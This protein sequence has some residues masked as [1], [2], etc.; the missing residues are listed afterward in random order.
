[1]KIATFLLINAIFLVLPLL[2]ES[3]PPANRTQKVEQ[4]AVQE[5]AKLLKEDKELR[6]KIKSNKNEDLG[7]DGK[8]NPNLQELSRKMIDRFDDLEQEKIREQR[9]LQN[10][11]RKAEKQQENPNVPFQNTDGEDPHEVIERIKER[12]GEIAE[13][14]RL[15]EDAKHQEFMRYEYEKLLLEKKNIEEMVKEQSKAAE[16]DKS[17]HSNS[18]EKAKLHHPGSKAQLQDVWEKDDGFSQGDFSPRSFFAA[19]D[20]NG[21]GQ[22]DFAELDAIMQRESH[23]LTKNDGSN[24]EVKMRKITTGMRNHFVREIDTNKDALI[25]LDE[26]IKA[27]ES[28]EFEHD[29]GWDPEREDNEHMDPEEFMRYEQRIREAAHF[30]MEDPENRE[31]LRM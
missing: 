17:G 27:S 1:M 30:D 16:D 5:T 10:Q 4:L 23:K 20:L 3:R 25:S 18:E 22:L 8:I 21:D 9:K 14:I 12:L 15:V 7:K 19:H 26:F 2:I 6:E 29:E 24:D 31:F 13:G 28:K 11:L